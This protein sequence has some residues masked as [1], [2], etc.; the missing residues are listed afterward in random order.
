[1][2]LSR[3]SADVLMDVSRDSFRVT[4]AVLVLLVLAVMV[5]DVNRCT[6]CV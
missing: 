6:F 5:H 3:L 2:I 1:V 4:R